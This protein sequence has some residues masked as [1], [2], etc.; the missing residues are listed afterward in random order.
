MAETSNDAVKVTDGT[1]K[2]V[3]STN[4][5]NGTIAGEE[6]NKSNGTEAVAEAATANDEKDQDG[7]KENEASDKD[8]DKSTSEHKRKHPPDQPESSDAHEIRR[9]VEFYFSN[10]NLPIDAFL[11]KLTGGHRNN[12]VPLKV[13]H[14]FKRMRHFQPYSAVRDA[15]KQSSVLDLNDNDEVTRKIPLSE[16]FTDDPNYNRKLVHT[17]SMS[18]SIYVKGFGEENKNTHLDI[19]AFFAPY[20]PISSVRLRRKDDGLFK[21]SVFVEFESEENQ[22]RFLA[23]D[24]K[25]QWVD[26]EDLQIMS[27]Q[28]YVD[29]K[30]QGILDGT[31]K[32]K[33]R[34]RRSGRGRG[35]GRG[36]R[37][38]RGG[39]GGRNRSPDRSNGKRKLN[40]DDDGGSDRDDGSPRRSEVNKK[41]KTEKEDAALSNAGVEA[42]KP[43]PVEGEAVNGGERKV[44]DVQE[45]VEA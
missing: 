37:G 24:P 7:G 20:G 31:V 18:R 39:H 1:E 40:D 34:D 16:T 10:S 36:G 29:M 2:E 6:E 23:L 19:E 44:T 25:P 35:R 12:P 13:I 22:Q 41:A 3:S 33:N 32:P 27:K 26:G 9:Q 8:S 42:E 28:E 17:A 5:A 30:H 45:S 38:D 15:V 14:D 21:G 4:I 11:L 43:G